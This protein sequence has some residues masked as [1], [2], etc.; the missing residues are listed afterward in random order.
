ME[1][2]LHTPRSSLAST[3]DRP[4]VVF[5]DGADFYFDDAMTGDFVGAVSF[6]KI[7]DFDTV[8]AQNAR[9]A[10]LEW[11]AAQDDIEWTWEA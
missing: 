1:P 9:M 2:T 10:F 5:Q 11:V 6:G 3:K 8:G 7:K 4:L